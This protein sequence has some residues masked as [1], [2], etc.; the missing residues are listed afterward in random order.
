MPWFMIPAAAAAG[1]S[2]QGCDPAEIPRLNG[3]A[4]ARGQVPSQGMLR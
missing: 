2:G 3:A 1:W 4:W